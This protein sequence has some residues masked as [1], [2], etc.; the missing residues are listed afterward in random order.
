MLGCAAAL[1]CAVAPLRGQETGPE[2]PDAEAGGRAAAPVGAAEKDA[3]PVPDLRGEAAAAAGSRLRSATP[4]GLLSS[5]DLPYAAAFFG[6]LALIEPLDG[7]EAEIGLAGDQDASGF[8][9]GF[10][11]AGAWAG[12]LW[13]DL[14]AAAV[15][16]GTGHLAG[17]RRVTRAGLRSLESLAVVDLLATLFKVSVGRQRPEGTTRPDIFRPMSWS[18]EYASF[19]S[20]HTAHAFALASAASRELGGWA[21]WVAYPLAAGVGASRVI[22]RRHWPTD[23]VA[24]AALGLFAARL[25]ARLHR[26]PAGEAGDGRFLAI[27]PGPGPGLLIAASLPAR[28][29][30]EGSPTGR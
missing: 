4:R 1:W 10:Y 27:L 30:A 2:T 28:R 13:V 3:A 16:L 7:L 23:I 22:G 6:S 14:G 5:S 26:S 9:H 20:G 18:H 15:T 21:P 19:P 24:G 25:T 8:D 29:G 11:S 12:N 17:S